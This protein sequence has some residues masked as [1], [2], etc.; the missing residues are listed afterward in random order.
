MD[1][2]DYL[3]LG[4]GTAGSAA[5][6]A[7]SEAGA[8]VVMFNEGELG[9]LCILRGCMPTKTLLHAAHRAHHARESE[10]PGVATALQSIDFRA[11]MEN[12]DAKDR[13]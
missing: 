4:G 12:K 13:T 6:R 10:T 9:G 1:D 8:R 7:A 11:V 3:I 5:A 2:V